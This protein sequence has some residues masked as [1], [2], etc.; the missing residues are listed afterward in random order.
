[1]ASWPT[2]PDAHGN[3]ATENDLRRII[4]A[5]YM[6]QGI[7][8]N[9]GLEVSGRSDMSY[10]VDSGVAFMWTSQSGRLGVLV[11]VESVTVPTEAAPATGMR[12]DSIYVLQDGVP[13]VTS[14]EVPAAGVLLGQF[15]IG[16]GV[17]STSAGQKTIDRSY[18]VPTGGALGRMAHWTDPGGGAATMQ[19]SVKM[20]QQF[21]L[22]SDSLVEIRAT[23]TLRS[24]TVPGSM[25]FDMTLESPAGTVRRRLDVAHTPDWDTRSSTWSFGTG[26][27]ENVLTVKTVGTKGGTWQ[28]SSGG[29]VTEVSLWHQGV[30]R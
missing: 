15:I 5:Q 12:I 4:G 17:T 1:M 27:G 19:E 23:T 30:L 20:V 3:G 24:V 22:P 11:P 18:A 9:G 29:S 6:T 8:P 2:A 16:A 13:R 7:L 10:Q 14:G 26:A 28:F 21:T 25:Y